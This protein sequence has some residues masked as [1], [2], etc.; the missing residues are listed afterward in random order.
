MAN[1]QNP[2][3]SS[4]VRASAGSGKTY[5][6]S[7][8]FLFLV[9]AG[10]QP[11]SILTVTFTKKAAAEMR[12]RILDLA[13][14]LLGNESEREEFES[15]LQRFYQERQ[16]PHTPRPLTAMET[17]S[18]ILASTQSLKISTIDSI[19]LEWLKK[20]PYEASGDGALSIPPQFDLMSV[21]HEAKAERK[22]FART[23]RKFSEEH[24]E[25]LQ[26]LLDN[27][28][29]VHF[30]GIEN[31]L[32][33][34]QKHE[35]FLWLLKAQSP[36]LARLIEHPIDEDWGDAGEEGLIEAL[37]PHFRSFIDTIAPGR[38]EELSLALG[39]KS[40]EAMRQGKF[41]TGELSV[42][43]NTFR[44]AKKNLAHA[45]AI[46]TIDRLTLSYAAY[47]LK[48]RLNATGKVLMEIFEA[49]EQEL[50]KLKFEEGQLGFG[51]LIKGGFYLFSHDDAVGARYLL[52]RSIRH[53]L[54]DEFQDT[55]II[56]WTVFKSMAEEML[57][58]A[59]YRSPDELDPTLFIVGDAKQ[60]I[61]GFREADAEIL[62]TAADFMIRRQAL[63][64]ELSASYRTHPLILNFVN[65]ALSE[66][67]DR[68]PTHVPAEHKGE[69]LI[70]GRASVLISPLFRASD[71]GGCG[72]PILDEANFIAETIY[73]RL[74][75]SEKV[76]DKTLKGYRTLRASDCAVLFRN[77]THA[78]SYADALR[79]KG[80]SVRIEE[81]QSFFARSEIRDLLALTRLLAYPG[82]VQS[83]YHVL[84][85]PLI[86]VSESKILEAMKEIRT[87]KLSGERKR[88]DLV[89]PLFEALGSEALN[90][91]NFHRLRHEKRPILGL[92]AFLRDT[93]AIARYLG[94]FGEEDGLLAL[95]NIQKFLELVLD[96]DAS[97]RLSWMEVLS[98]LEGKEKEQAVSLSAVSD[99]AVQLLTIHKAKGLEWPLVVLSG[100]GEEWE[101]PDLYWAKLKESHLGSGLSYVGKR[102]E[103]QKDDPHF[104]ALS[105]GLLEESLQENHR[106]LYVALTRAQYEL[107]VT[108]YQ[109]KDKEDSYFHGLLT[110]TATQLSYRPY[111]VRDASLYIEAEDDLPL[112]PPSETKLKE[113]INLSHFQSR[114]RD[115]ASVKIL[116]PARL[117]NDKDDGKTLNESQLA[118][119]FASEAG[120]YIHKALELSMKNESFDSLSFW[121]SLRRHHPKKEFEGAYTL[122]QSECEKTLRSPAW[123]QLKKDALMFEV[124]LPI[125]YLKDK[126][127]VRGVIDLLV[128][129]DQT[130]W[131]I[132]DYK[133]SWEALHSTDLLA[134]CLEKKYD[135]QLA[136]YREGVSRLYPEANVECAVFF[137][138]RQTLVTLPK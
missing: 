127:L 129:K 69:T 62:G 53:L 96:C 66:V 118:M 134:L 121:A 22:A 86:G 75:N 8:R 136:L 56:Q 47:L 16:N 93:H 23:L 41:L 88:S 79:A 106:L 138:A 5:Q 107:V 131:L 24:D 46:E 19:L 137:T 78:R 67:I 39:T 37:A 120:T 48:R 11:S 95:A 122:V 10:A 12:A 114:Y 15:Q 81:G 43:G 34:L 44:T 92:E 52:N 125:A 80:L 116:A 76:Y 60:S 21:V 70:K 45:N 89:L 101:R 77:S 123:I 64:I 57:S 36:H 59:G 29:D 28:E 63:D 68:F 99:D 124:E 113:T 13:A 4:V 133:T 3:R 126:M 74:S 115:H 98:Y 27:P 2:Y 30:V 109:R 73:G 1:P 54:L 33:E 6:L 61:Y 100:T 117:L 49:F 31:R 58:G 82:D 55:S 91:A 7:R 20:F 112:A 32:K 108:G 90:L 110:R 26:E 14:K 38:Q 18:R 17:A 84:K 35:S 102:S 42:H 94:S 71:P 25:K 105:K 9:G 87:N 111:G 103:L 119:P 40:I 83:A 51:D 97:S 130:T 128:K 132:V 85:S 135:Q 104:H 72:N 65:H 50:A